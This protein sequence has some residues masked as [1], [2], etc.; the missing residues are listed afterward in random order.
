[1][2]RHRAQRLCLLRAA[3]RFPSSRPG[4]QTYH[5]AQLKAAIDTFTQWQLADELSNE[6]ERLVAKAFHQFFAGEG[7]APTRLQLEVANKL[8]RT[9]RERL[10]DALNSIGD[11]PS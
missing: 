6:A 9:A 1:M 11:A 4:S 3:H 7:P 8:R 5:S 10:R 2:D